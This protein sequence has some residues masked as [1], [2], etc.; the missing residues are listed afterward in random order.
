MC[1]QVQQGRQHSLYAQA[2]QTWVHRSRIRRSMAVVPEQI[3][4]KV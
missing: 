1:G 3:L 2:S 4:F